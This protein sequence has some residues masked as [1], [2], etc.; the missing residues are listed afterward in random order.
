MNSLSTNAG[1]LI[2]DTTT[3]SCPWL[4]VTDMGTISKRIL[5]VRA[6]RDY[7]VEYLVQYVN[8]K[9]RTIT[10]TTAVEKNKIKIDRKIF[11]SYSEVNIGSGRR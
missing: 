5:L 2:S 10:N 9:F 3:N 1:A 7:R 8:F 4:E 11:Y 6:E